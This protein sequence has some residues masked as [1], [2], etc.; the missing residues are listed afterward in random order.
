[1]LVLWWSS[2]QYHI[3]KYHSSGLPLY[4]LPNL[5]VKFF[6]TFSFLHRFFWCFDPTCWTISKKTY[7]LFFDFNLLLKLFYSS[8]KKRAFSEAFC[9]HFDHLLIDFFGI[10][11]D[12]LLFLLKWSFLFNQIGL[13][14]LQTSYFLPHLLDIF[15]RLPN[16]QTTLSFF[17]QVPRCPTYLI[18]QAL[19]FPVLFLKFDLQGAE[20][21]LFKIKL[22]LELRIVV[23]WI[24]ACCQDDFVLLFDL[25]IVINLMRKKVW[26]TGDMGT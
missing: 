24:S 11:F 12:L 2:I 1:M 17:F 14:F 21:L 3:Y 16:I 22:S 10:V 19:K 15:F 9:F 7:L 26:L 23:Y 13:L 8:G 20:L 18:C 6:K 5:Q 25:R 4:L